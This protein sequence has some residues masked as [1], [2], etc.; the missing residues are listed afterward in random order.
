MRKI[1]EVI[2]YIGLNKQIKVGEGYKEVN[3]T[4]GT[5]YP[6]RMG[7]YAT[8]DKEIQKALESAPEFGS[9]Y[10]LVQAGSKVFDDSLPSQSNMEQ[11]E[12][13]KAKNQELMREVSELRAE[14][15][16]LSKEDIPVPPKEVPGIVNGQ[17]AKEY[18]V[19]TFGVEA[20]KLKNKMLILNAAKK[21]NVTFPD[22]K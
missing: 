9:E 6:R 16:K 19:D 18:I 3:F 11:V 15:K 12:M 17:Q 14:L 13:L 2:G 7:R 5:L 21:Y 10:K 22:W 4:G 20:D 1:Y 8:D